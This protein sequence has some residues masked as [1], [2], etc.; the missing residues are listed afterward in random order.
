MNSCK[1]MMKTAAFLAALLGGR[2][3][4]AAALPLTVEITDGTNSRTILVEGE[5]FPNARSGP[6]GKAQYRPRGT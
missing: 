6:T 2:L 1:N 4:T 3:A 5:L